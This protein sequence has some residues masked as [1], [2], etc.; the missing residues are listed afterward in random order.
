MKRRYPDGEASLLGYIQLY[1]PEE[2]A[3]AL[4]NAAADYEIRYIPYD[5]LLNDQEG[6]L[7]VPPPKKINIDVKLYL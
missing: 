5:W 2:Q 6:R 3:T 1:L 7:G 4:G